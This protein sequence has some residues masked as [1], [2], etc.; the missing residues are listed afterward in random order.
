M[1]VYIKPGLWLVYYGGQSGY[2]GQIEGCIFF[3]SEP[4]TNAENLLSYLEE[5][6]GEKVII[7]NMVRVS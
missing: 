7:K 3:V 4:K 2:G 6:V 1:S 5:K